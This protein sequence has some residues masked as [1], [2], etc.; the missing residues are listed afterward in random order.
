MNVPSK[1]A[2]VVQEN[3]ECGNKS[4]VIPMRLFSLDEAMNAAAATHGSHPT[5]SRVAIT[6]DTS[7]YVRS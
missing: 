4:C 1:D 2:V 7:A 3:D 5:T 6:E